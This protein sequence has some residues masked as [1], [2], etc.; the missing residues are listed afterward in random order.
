[1]RALI[2]GATG[3]I[4]SHLAEDLLKRGYEVTCLVRRTSNLQW[5]EGLDVRL[6]EGDCSDKDSLQDCVKNQD[7][8]LHLAGLIK[9]N[10]K[11]DF[12]SIN[13][14]G[15]ENII[16]AVRQYNPEIKRFV[17]L[18]S[19]SAFGPKTRNE[20]PNEG[21][22]PNPVSDYGK[23]KL[24]SETIVLKYSNI[25]PVTILRPAV[26]YGPRDRGFFLLFKLI[27]K[28]FLPYWGNGHTSLVY[29]DDLIKAILLTVE[30]ENAIGKIFFISDGIVYSNNEIIEEI[31]SALNVKCLRIRLP[32]ALLPV[33]SFFCE[34]ISKIMGKTTMINSDKIKEV[35]YADWVCDITKARSELG[36]E[37][38]VGIKQ[39][40][41][42][43]ADW[44]KIHRWL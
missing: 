18:S 11:E 5:L 24:K 10:C 28:G 15:T 12:Y 35:M 20:L 3:F 6:N 26:V 22:A 9:S 8:I 21:C 39:G 29:V 38:K 33:I 30:Q 40:I 36:F 7:Y 1:M 27:K 19:L 4:G 13:T 34:R 31:A 41:K 43:T 23:S 37:P 25:L 14:K 17:H 16:E 42:W 2:T 44:Y 32:R